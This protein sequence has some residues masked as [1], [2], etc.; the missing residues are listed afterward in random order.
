MKKRVYLMLLL[1][2]VL[3]VAMIGFKHYQVVQKRQRLKQESIQREKMLKTKTIAE[4]KKTIQTETVGAVSFQEVILTQPAKIGLVFPVLE[5]Q[6]I[7]SQINQKIDTAL[8][9]FKTKS[10]QKTDAFYVVMKASRFKDNVYSIY[11]E[12]QEDISGEKSKI[13]Y[14]YTFDLKSGQLLNWSDFLIKPEYIETLKRFLVGQTLKPQESFEKIETLPFSITSDKVMFY[15]LASENLDVFSIPLSQITA[16]LKPEYVSEK[17]ATEALQVQNKIMP[18][19]DR[20]V[21]LTP[22][23]SSKK[24]VALTFDDGPNPVTTRQL[25]GILKQEQ[26][27]ATFFVLGERAA[28]YPEIVKEAY[29]EGHQIASHTMNHRNLVKVSREVAQAEINQAGATI[30]NITGK[31]PNAVRPPYGATNDQ[32]NASYQAAVVLWDVDSLDWQSKNPDAIYTK[33]M[34]EVQDGSIILLHDIH[35][36]TIS[37]VPRI[38]NDLKQAGYQFVTVEQLISSRTTLENGRQYRRISPN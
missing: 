36:T 7:S 10:K 20:N 35:P 6:K 29:D 11:Y 3:F 18:I 16:I 8:A 1:I 15:P 24:L 21:P 33:V 34:S 31:Y 25:L 12:I 9:A 14:A 38:M 37:A 26:T 28:Q 30:T 32:L 17:V 4:I 19:I 13:S 2:S 22:E 5:N 27:I 23:M